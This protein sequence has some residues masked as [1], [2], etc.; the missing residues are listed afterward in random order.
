MS[1]ST[2]ESREA[3]VLEETTP[4]ADGS[5]KNARRQ[6]FGLGVFAAATT[7]LTE[8]RE[9]ASA[10]NN[11]YDPTATWK[12]P[13]VRLARRISYGLTQDEVDAARQMGFQGYL[14]YQLGLTADADAELE[15]SIAATFPR[16]T[17]SSYDNYKT[18]QDAGAARTQ[19]IQATIVRSI[20]SGRQLYQRMVEFWT[21]H[22]N[23]GVK[24]VIGSA[25][26]VTD[27]RDVIRKYALGT[28]PNLLKAT[29]HSPCMLHYLDN[30]NSKKANPNQNYAR[31]ILELHTLGVDGGYS[32]Q[33]VVEVAR[34]FTGWGMVGGRT[35]VNWG[36]FLFTAN[37]HDQGQ[38]IVL[39]N[40][41]APNGGQSDGD[42]VLNILIAHPSTAKFI[43]TKMAKF[44]LAYDPPQSVIDATAATY[45]ATNGNIKMMI[46]TIL[47]QANLMAAPAKY[48]RPYQVLVAAI[49]SLMPDV[50]NF[51][52]LQA[53]ANKLGQLPYAWSPPDGYPDDIYYWAGLIL[54]RWNLG[55]SLLNNGLAGIRLDTSEYDGLG[56]AAAVVDLLNARL[57]GY[58]M[59]PALR[60]ELIGHMNPFNPARVREAIAI[61]V[62][63]PDFQ[64]Y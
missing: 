58:E 29:A 14:N 33:D 7:L 5:R 56:T 4:N 45:T 41:I 61:A 18:N 11:D 52:T 37:N 48:R 39:G 12:H 57:F 35:N 51:A 46:R 62:A 44:L 16:T 55:F 15:A 8:S 64:W 36:K 9:Q 60:A 54:P 53:Q 3:T 50:T 32:Q 38:K 19:L 13:A 1:A 47:T 31:E 28:F 21:D 26:K 42:Q 20:Y 23:D 10:Q 25:L 27:D 63:S 22:F 49:R 30:D 59:T 17:Y 2:A 6:L 24:G 40:T 34:A 43:A